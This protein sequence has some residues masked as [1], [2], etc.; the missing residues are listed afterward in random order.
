MRTDRPD[1]AAP[2]ERP[3]RHGSDR[4]PLESREDLPRNSSRVARWM[5]A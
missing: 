5:S 4:R 2:G 1:E 3:E